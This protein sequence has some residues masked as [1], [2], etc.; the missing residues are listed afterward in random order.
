M[1]IFISYVC[2]LESI[3]YNQKSETLIPNTYEK[4]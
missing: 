2:F 3:C 1:Q 4:V